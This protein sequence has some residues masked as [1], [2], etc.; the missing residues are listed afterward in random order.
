MNT[1]VERIVTTG[2]GSDD[3]R[4]RRLLAQKRKLLAQEGTMA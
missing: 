3:A 4:W 2:R 1:G